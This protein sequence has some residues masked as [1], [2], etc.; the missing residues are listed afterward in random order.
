[1]F[2]RLLAVPAVFKRTGAPIMCLLAGRRRARSLALIVM[3]ALLLAYGSRASVPAAYA[4]TTGV[5]SVGC[6]FLASAIDGDTTDTVAISDYV[7]ACNSILPVE[8]TLLADA[9]GDAD[10]VLEKSDLDYLD[11]RDGNQVSV[12]CAA[13]GVL[14]T[15]VGFVFVD[16][17]APVTIDLPAGLVTDQSGALDWVCDTNAEDLDCD[18]STPNDGDG[19][20]T[21]DLDNDTSSPGDVKTVF[22][23]QEAVVQSFDVY[24]VGAPY[25]V[26]L[27]LTETVIQT[28]GY[29]A[30]AAACMTSNDVA[31]P[32]SIAQPTTTLGVAT[33]TDIDG[34]QLTRASVNITSG[35]TA[36]A[37]IATGD[38]FT[39]IVGNTGQT[40]SAGADGVA[41]FFVICGGMATG[42]SLIS[43]TI[44]PHGGGTYIASQT[45]TVVGAPASMVLTAS[46]AQ[47]LCNAVETSTITA[48]LRDA[49]GD[50]VASG[51][52]VNFTV[53]LVGIVNP[54][55]AATTAG[56]ASTT[57]RGLSS[58]TIGVPVIV[59][60][61]DV[62]AS[63]LISCMGFDTDGDGLPNVFEA[64][65][66]CLNAQVSD[67]TGDPDADAVT[68]LLE[69]G[70]TTDGDGFKDKPSTSGLL[71]N[72]DVNEDNCPVVANADQTNTDANFIDLHVFGKLFDDITVVY[73]DSQGN[74][75]DADI[76]NDGLSN[77]VE[78]EAGPAGS[79]HAQCLAATGP[80]DP[81][82][83]DT[84]DDLV[85]DAAEC[86]MGTDPVDAASKPPA[87]P[88]GDADH[89]GLT[90]AFEA[91]I[92]TNPALV[93]TDG[94]RL[95]DSVEYKGYNA[96][97]LVLDTDGDVCSD[98]RE[99]ASVNADV[100]VNSLDM[101]TVASH[102]GPRTSGRYIKDFDVNRDGNINSTDMLIQA[103]L[104][105]SLPC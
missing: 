40:V 88:A 102:F 26:S 58:F 28:N 91:I 63:I 23:E 82:L 14:C 7:A 3:T 87:A 49:N 43:A 61:G 84:D 39:G 64:A 37:V 9:L 101:V 104:F 62:Q 85:L 11:A 19:V 50:L 74:A 105:T 60:S 17:D 83:S 96:N 103:K 92:G 29:P 59:T 45:V 47:V 90:D 6:E 67:S 53:V 5:S 70:N 55:N 12:T 15:I 8:V 66:A 94:D 57:F 36:A 100:K 68:S 32:S 25:D 31:A 2:A 97:P 78:A 79:A 56:V 44:D 16:D 86:A 98:G 1:M 76:D 93:D 41:Q 75:C 27:A 81:L 24:V 48:T 30:A 95:L 73:S 71:V 65:H 80:T 51:V 42:T 38:A 52:P 54:I 72:T 4:E 10:G 46:P 35:T 33:V 20:V 99:A 13:M 21:F 69:F 77:A 89:D 34:R 22:V 18:D